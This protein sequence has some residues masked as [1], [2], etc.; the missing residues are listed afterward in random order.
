MV[1]QYVQSQNWVMLQ[2]DFEAKAVQEMESNKVLKSSLV[3]CFV[4]VLISSAYGK[5]NGEEASFITVRKENIASSSQPKIH[6]G[7]RPKL[8]QAQVQVFAIL[9]ISNCCNG[10]F[11]HTHT[12]IFKI[13]K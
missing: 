10:P 1:N 4:E 7:N 13:S 9:N 11:I 5:W 6:T 12:Y 8:L 3:I 2:L